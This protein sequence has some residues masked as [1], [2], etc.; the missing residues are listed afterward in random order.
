M[1]YLHILSEDKNDDVFY[2][3]CLNKIT[4]KSFE[5]ISTHPEKMS[6]ISLVRSFL[7][8]FLKN[9]QRTGSIGGQSY[10]LVAVD[11]DRSP[12]HPLHSKRADFSKLPKSDQKK[13]CRQCE[14]ERVVSS[15]LGSDRNEWSVKGAIAIPVE[16]MESW[17][18]LICSS[19]TFRNERNLPIFPDKNARAAKTYYT[20]QNAPNQLKDLV[21]QERRKLNMSSQEFC[22]YCA[23]QLNVNDL[24]ARS[25]SF[26]QLSEQV[27]DW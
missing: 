25:R 22:R 21:R 12:I 4:G 3:N 16:M 5:I 26:T 13:T 27:A 7:P 20:S 17:Q 9:I 24:K 15:V 18:L 6:G 11:N 1:S 8:S 10:F 2:Q 14:I 23:Q 19:A